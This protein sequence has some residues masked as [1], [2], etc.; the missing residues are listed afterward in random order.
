MSSERRGGAASPSRRTPARLQVARGTILS[1]AVWDLST[2]LIIMILVIILLNPINILNILNP[3]ILKFSSSFF[4][5]LCTR[6][7]IVNSHKST[8]YLRYICLQPWPAPRLGRAA[9]RRW[10]LTRGRSPAARR[11]GAG[12]PRP[13]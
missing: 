9:A 13:S 5:L 7:H 11:P 2:C 6:I 12:R 10:C 4:Y 8:V 1:G 3:H